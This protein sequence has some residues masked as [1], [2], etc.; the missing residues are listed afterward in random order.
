MVKIKKRSTTNKVKQ[1][2]AKRFFK[3]VQH[4][5]P[6]VAKHWD[7]KKSREYNMKTMGLAHDVN[8]AIKGL[9]GFA[10]SCEAV[11]VVHTLELVDIPQSEDLANNGV[12]DRRTPL[13]EEKQKYIVALMTRYGD[14]VGK[15]ARDTKRNP[16]QETAAHLR[17]MIK[18]YRSLTD[19]QRLV[20]LPA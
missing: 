4:N 6:E 20:P 14:D 13:P 17:K 18:K 12:N 1:K 19:K 16:Q 7:F 11:K 3:K 10:P 5:D 15:M 9:P 8:R 2:Q